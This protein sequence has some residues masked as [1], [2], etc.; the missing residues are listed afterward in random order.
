MTPGCGPDCPCQHPFFR[1]A[2]GTKVVFSTG[3]VWVYDEIEPGVFL[4]CALAALASEG[5]TR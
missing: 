5:A 3:E 2:D 1:P 4:S